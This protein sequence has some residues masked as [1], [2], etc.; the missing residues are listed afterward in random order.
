[1]EIIG[2]VLV[3]FLIAAVYG[4]TIALLF[5]VL[6]LGLI[7][8]LPVG[9]IYGV[10]NYI[11]S[12]LDNIDNQLFKITMMVLTSLIIIITLMFFAAVIYYFYSYNYY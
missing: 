9:I 5:S 8:G 3:L 12:I 11:S 2:I 7:V 4:F 6:G 10:K 1:M